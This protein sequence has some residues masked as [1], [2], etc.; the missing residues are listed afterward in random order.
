MNTI[1]LE[2]RNQRHLERK[3]VA[4]LLQWGY[5]ITPPRAEWVTMRAV[6]ERF[7]ITHPSQL[8]R[9]LSDPS[10]PDFPGKD[11]S[12]HRRRHKIV[13]TPA[14]QKFLLQKLSDAKA[15]TAYRPV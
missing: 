5:G 13:V 12:P 1:T 4:M 8:N 15:R 9:L 7:R 14:L 11:P 10:C 3:V 6:Q 2:Y